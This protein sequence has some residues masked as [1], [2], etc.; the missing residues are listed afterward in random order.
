MPQCGFRT[1]IN[2]AFLFILQYTTMKL[3]VT[4]NNVAHELSLKTGHTLLST[5]R[6]NKLD[7]PF[8][9]SEGRCGKCKAKLI[10]GV[11]NQESGTGLG[12]EDRKQG[13]ILT[14]RSKGESD[15]VEVEFH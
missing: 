8:S 13:Y 7:P 2:W 3:K 10:S 12:I 5:L 15:F 14:C 6:R 9:C 1:I 11:V 4:L